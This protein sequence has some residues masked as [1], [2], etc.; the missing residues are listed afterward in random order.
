ML[1]CLSVFLLSASV[2]CYEILVIRLLAVS[3]W[4]PFVTLAISTALLGFGISGTV[5]AKAAGPLFS[6]RRMY[7]PM[8]AGLAAIAYRPMAKAAGALHLE[9][10]LIVRDPWQWVI[11][12]LVI[13]SL[14]IPFVFASL[15]LALPLLERD[16][17]GRYYGWN[18]IGSCA[19]ALLALGALA[20]LPTEALVQVPAAA[21]AGS[22]G[23][24]L[25]HYHKGSRFRVALPVVFLTLLALVPYGP[26]RFG[27]YKDISYALLLPEASI[28][29]EMWGVTGKLQA[30]S[31]P[32]I[33]SAAG[34]STRYRGTLPRQAA[35]YRDGDRV[36]TLILSE[37]AD[38]PQLD[39]L[40]WQTAAS[41][42][43]LPRA[44]R[45]VAI[46][47]FDGGEEVVRGLVYG[48][49]RVVLV[50]PDPAAEQIIR[51]DEDLF[52][53]WI[54][55][56]GTAV[57]RSNV[58]SF[59]GAEV[60]KFDTVIFPATGNLAAATA[61]LTGTA[62]SYNL[63]VEGLTAALNT[64]KKG[65]IIAING[66][67]QEP[68]TGRLKILSL[69][70]NMNAPG[71]KPNSVSGVVMV[72]GWST[73]TILLKHDPFSDQEYAA[74]RE[75]CEKR[76]YLVSNGQEFQAGSFPPEWKEEKELV[77]GLDLRPPTD[78]RPYPWHSLR[79]SLFRH[80]AGGGRET[81]FP[82]VE[83]GFFFLFMAL[84]LATAASLILMAVS[85][86]PKG[87][88]AADIFFTLYFSCLGVGYMV[89]EIMIIKRSGL[90][91][92]A[93]AVSAA[94]VLAGFLLFSGLGSL[95]A[96]RFSPGRR[97]L[98]AAFLLIPLSATGAYYLMPLLV[99]ADRIVRPFLVVLLAAPGAFLMGVPFPSALAGFRR[100]REA[101]VPWA[102]AV[103]GYT[104]VIGSSL[105]GVLAVTS[106][107]RALLVLGGSCYILAA[108]LF[109]RVAHEQ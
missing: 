53:K 57:V 107:F 1:L 59:L 85:R 33:R 19:G 103:S 94:A 15:A 63:T 105:A 29:S 20:Y 5:L 32:A 45:N 44:G 13:I 65:G 71:K 34:L 74:L 92:T 82:R 95:A 108:C 75:F 17:V 39:Y 18:L 56:R 54:F 4:Q 27:P 102:W 42:Y 68:P 7:Y 106:G 2:L 88:Y 47:G 73:H 48:A 99:D 81:V 8:L 49:S 90:V 16:T 26:V 23:A 86:P 67:N 62:E 41:V 31:A 21:A 52:K 78:D 6:S 46:L 101:L 9:P 72:Q 77:K 12:A 87:P 80:L 89:L 79:I 50:E 10:G 14:T 58:R 38:D 96:G 84:I 43:V 60:G 35:L 76:G 22:C 93:P 40:R 104:S 83:W 51:S 66:W 69:I 64:L 25:I 36:G 70:E 37:S 3:H 109:N 24:S 30:I 91:L 61:G 55:L 98:W 97:S 28:V 100:G 11:L